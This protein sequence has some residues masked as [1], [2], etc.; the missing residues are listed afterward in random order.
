MS[1]S[2]ETAPRPRRV[3]QPAVGPKL[4]ILL[5]AVFALVALLGANSL[6][7][8]SITCLDWASETWGTGVSYQNPFY[9]Y[10]VLAHIVLGLVL[11]VPFVT[12]G[13][14]HLLASKNR[15]NRRAVRIG[16]ALFAV[17]IAVLAT[18]LALVRIEGVLDLKHPLARSAVYWLHV[19][20]PLAAVWLYWLHRLA[21]P[22][23]KWRLGGVYAAAV[24]LIVVGMIVI[25]Q[26][27]PRKWYAVGPKDGEKYFFPSLVKTPD[28]KLIP[29]E[30]LTNNA[31]CQKCHADVHKGWYD[32]AHHFSSFNNPAYLAAVRET[33]QV[34]LKR[35]GSV[36]ASRWCAGCHDPVPFLSGAFD[37]PDF[38]DVKDPTAH[39]GI[40]C[41]VCHAM[42][43]INST[44]GN[45]D[46][47]IEEP[48]Q[49]PFT[50][51][52]DPWLQYVNQ[53][54]IKAKPSFHKK[55]FL[56]PFHRTAEFCSTC[57]KV[58][59]PPELNK[60]K[61][62]RGQNHYDT[63]LLSGVSGHGARSF[64]YPPES[65]PNCAGCHMPL[66]VSEDFG[67]KDFGNTGELSIH[68]HLFVGANTGVAWMRDAPEVIAAHQQFMK[69]V[70]R[71]DLFGIKEGGTVDGRL[72]AP[73]RP[74]V[75]EL[76]PGGTYLIEAVI[77]TLK[78]GHFFTQGTAD[79]NEVWVEVTVTCGGKVIGKSGGIDAASEVDPWSHF[80]NIFM[81]DREGNRIARRN[82]QDI[83]VPLYNHQIPPGAAQTAHYLIVLPEEL[84]SPVTVEVKLNYRKFDKQYMDF[85]TGTAKPGD[86][87]IRGHEAGKPYVNALP[88]TVLASDRVVF[89]VAGVSE[90]VEN[91]PSPIQETWQRWNDYGIGLYLEG[92]AE[93]RQT[94]EAF[95]QVETLGRYD[96]PL[97][98]AR[99]YLDEGLID[100]A[101]D[102]V[103]RASSMDP[104][105]PP[106][107]L[108]W[109]SGRI[110]LQQG[111]FELAEK[112]FRQVLGTRVPDRGF[113]FSLDFE[114]INLL[115]QTLFEQAK[116]I[117][118]LDRQTDRDALLQAAVEQFAKTLTIDP[119]NVPAHYNLHLLYSQLGEPDKAE[120]HR[121]WHARYKPDDNARD[122]AVALARQKYPAADRAAEALVR[123]DLRR[124]GAPG[125]DLPQ[126]SAETTSGGG[127]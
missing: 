40:T 43:N 73:L 92:K 103:R 66:Q 84:P 104:P 68:D 51:S 85:V 59:L 107:T 8:A 121:Q 25:H 36:Q 22:W 30:T 110:N 56:K 21:G 62:V 5:Y 6:Y 57:H 2:P 50:F 111:H 34:V 98:L 52:D 64:Y 80:V 126:A 108:A 123:Y 118:T 11:I 19:G 109:L 127:R 42:T 106:W 54:L 124:A 53:Q 61:W 1:T 75:P 89:P 48:Q 20:C 102:A 32:S 9:L 31:Y 38:D 81:L 24:G 13:V 125:L 69:E 58:H 120:Q 88:V 78:L 79:S 41:T 44:R 12:F 7:M 16:Y 77:R 115:G 23:I 116:R 26:Q 119:E 74:E 28:A 96:G 72:I 95:A 3:Y 112:D 83:F 35:D 27:D 39:E 67:A 14:I 99:A 46:F 90:S 63:Y 82:P 91:P 87:A 65:K 114:V 101:V 33:R 29:A 117:R 49:Y 18:G 55:T 47:T 70:V 15:K 105:P 45:A 76:K 71:I 60:Y 93:F 122:R 86:L 94:G 37:N 10:N 113:D 100:D 4:K 97:N 17:S